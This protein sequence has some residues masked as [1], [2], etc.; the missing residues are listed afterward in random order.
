MDVNLSGTGDDDLIAADAVV[1]AC[2]DVPAPTTLFDEAEG[3]CGRRQAD[4]ISDFDVSRVIASCWTVLPSK[5]MAL[6]VLREPPRLPAA[7]RKRRLRFHLF[8]AP[9]RPL[10]QRERRKE[11]LRGWWPAGGDQRRPELT[12]EQ[13]ALV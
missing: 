13:I 4:V 11:R 7:A 5:G 12:A 2:R 6:S 8:P 9:R 3:G 10:L 1:I